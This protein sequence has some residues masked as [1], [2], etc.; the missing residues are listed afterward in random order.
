MGCKAR[1][2]RLGRK[3]QVR[4]VSSGQVIAGLVRTSHFSSGQGCQVRSGWSGQDRSRESGHLGTVLVISSQSSLVGWLG[5]VRFA[6]SGQVRIYQFWTAD[7]RLVRS[8][9]VRSSQFMSGRS[10]HVG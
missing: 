4:S 2:V 10:G 8:V 3:I 9:Q 1:S 6:Q 7:F 5:Q